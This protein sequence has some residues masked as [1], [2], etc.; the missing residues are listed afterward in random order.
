MSTASPAVRV[1]AG[2]AGGV[3]MVA[4]RNFRQGE[5]ISRVTNRVPAPGPSTYS[6]QVGTDRHVESDSIRY[7]NHSCEPNTYIDAI[8]GMLLALQDIIEGDELTFFY[9]STE[10]DMASSFAC[11]CGTRDC[12]TSIRGARH[13]AAETLARYR[14]NDHIVRLLMKSEARRTGRRSLSGAEALV[15][16]LVNHD[17]EVIFGMPGFDNVEIYRYLSRYGLHHVGPRHEQA[18][19][20]AA[21]GYARVTGRPGVILTTTGPALL[22]VTAAAGQA[23]SDSVPMLLLSPGMPLSSGHGD[24]RLHETKNQ[25]AA[26]DAICAW[27]L[28]VTSVA[29]IPAA[30]GRAF[31]EFASRRPRPIHIE[32]P[33]DVLENV[34]EVVT[35]PPVEVTPPVPPLDVVER[36][37]RVLVSADNTMIVAGGG[38][39]GAS[40]E[41]TALAELLDAPVVTTVNGKGA[42]AESHRLAV[43]AGIHL[44]GVRQLA[45]EADIVLAVGTELSESDTWDGRLD[46]G[47]RLVRIDIDSGQTHRNA[48]SDEMLVGDA[49]D[50]TKRI[51]GVVRGLARPSRQRS[52]VAHDRIRDAVAAEAASLGKRWADLMA[53]LRQ[54]LPADTILT[55]DSSMACYYGAIA[56]F[57]MTEPSSFLY[58]TGF[59]TLGYALPAAIGAKV[60]HP[61]RPVAALTGDGGLQFTIN[62]L[63]TGVALGRPLPVVVFDNGGY[64]LMRQV[65]E[66]RGYAPIGA[67]MRN[68]DFVALAEAYGAHGC[69]ANTPTEVGEAVTAALAVAGPTLIVVPDPD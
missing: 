41:L 43:G 55:N 50:V 28:R 8:A 42:I 34:A 15:A 56:M 33:V 63:A 12:L 22:N 53:M 38:A 69:V 59:G 7:L 40:T 54:A 65:M 25:S 10:W 52:T 68:P 30:V 31:A 64:G 20:Y 37:A 27:S 3:G 58:P 16:A 11:A 17:V 48:W 23:Y 39:R 62:E 36:V 18:A 1:V 46:I 67:D 2:R 26:M 21:D 45:S 19:G 57:P 9:P 35:P 13:T 29:E 24:G 44:R 49:A 4:A 60:A 51:S 61:D 66:E 47:G 14:L 5:L 32:I 6:I